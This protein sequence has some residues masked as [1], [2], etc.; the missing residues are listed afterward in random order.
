MR[1]KSVLV[2]GS[3]RGIGLAI[4]EAFLAEGAR[5]A[6]NG[7]DA[8]KLEQVVARQTSGEAISVEGDVSKADQAKGTVEQVLTAFGTLDI[9][10]CNVGSGRS[11]PPGAETQ[12]EW[13]RMFALNLWSVT[14]MVEAGRS[15]LAKSHGAIVCISSICGQEVISGAPLTY[16]AAKAALN[17][18][19][20]GIARPLGKDGVRINAVAP[21][22]ILFDGSVWGNKLGEDAA[23]VERM[24][25][26]DVALA[27]LG[28]PQEV[29]SL[30]LWLASCASSF[31]TG[32]VFVADGGQVRS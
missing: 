1:G 28:S 12:D 32:G 31:C 7:R 3:S 27:K 10:V 24:L 13:Q 4:A 16:S 6:F 26:R 8:I 22:N 21:G 15:A 2:T 19:V 29:A 14:N 20:R 30:T 5:V 25:E 11:V 9:L 18:Y 17:S 23:S